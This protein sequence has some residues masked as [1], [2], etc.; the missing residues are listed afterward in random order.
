MKFAFFGTGPLADSALLT[1]QENGILP[2]LIVTKKNAPVGRKQVITPP[3]T[4]L[5]GEQYD[6]PVFQPDTLKDLVDSPLHGEVFDFFVVAS[7]GKIIPQAI[8][9]LPKSG[10]LNIH[11]SKLPLYRGPT[12]IESALLAG[13]DTLWLSLM[14]L[15]AEMDHGPIIE[16]AEFLHLVGNECITAEE[17]E[18]IAGMRGALLLKPYLEGKPI[19][20]APQN[21]EEATFTKK[22]TKELGEISLTD[23]I[24]KIARTYRATT[25]WP[26]CFFMH[27]H[28]DRALRIKITNMEYIDGVYT[29]THVVPEGKKEMTFADFTRGYGV[30]N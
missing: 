8:L 18:A 25:P 26:G 20:S 13:D 24:E 15:D 12:P 4:K 7:Y 19:L 22:F 17:V 29:I 10:T 21:H 28:G 27:T 3:N 5:F 1:L 23:D 9:D 2:T 16:Q 11:P 14:V 6:V 30:H